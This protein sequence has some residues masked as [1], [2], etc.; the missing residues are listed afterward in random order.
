MLVIVFMKK[1]TGDLMR[2]RWKKINEA[3][4]YE[5]S[6]NGVVRNTHT[7][8]LV[9]Q[10]PNYGYMYVSLMINGKAHQRRV[11]RLVALA[12]IPNPENK[13]D[14]NHID[15]NKANN[16]VS[17]LEWCTASENLHHAYE[18]GLREKQALKAQKAR[19]KKI[20]R[21]DGVSFVSVT[22][23]ASNLGVTISQM[24]KILRG[25]RKAKDGRK[26]AYQ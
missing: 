10:R 9:K 19:R 16:C 3:P 6:E 4:M 24:S 13:S 23:A 11:H 15:G 21:D 8:N 12:F 26:Y 17:N 22:E 1:E 25:T 18:T 7:G 20:I 14:V 5:V 2:E